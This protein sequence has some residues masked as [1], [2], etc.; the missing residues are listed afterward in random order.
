M[1]LMRR[2]GD[3]FVGHTYWHPLL[4]WVTIEHVFP[5]GACTISDGKGRLW[6]V[7]HR[8]LFATDNQR[9]DLLMR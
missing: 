7:E 1:S 8:A 5:S 9:V 4:G 2:L 3:P 6:N